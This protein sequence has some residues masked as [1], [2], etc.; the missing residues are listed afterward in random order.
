[1]TEATHKGR[2]IDVYP[3][4]RDLICDEIGLKVLRAAAEAMTEAGM[5][6]VLLTTYPHDSTFQKGVPKGKIKAAIS[7]GD[8]NRLNFFLQVTDIVRLDLVN[9][10]KAPS[11]SAQIDLTSTYARHAVALLRSGQ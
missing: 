5:G 11:I 2:D 9:E 4:V 10:A 8:E 7:T 1:M 3:G 6:Y